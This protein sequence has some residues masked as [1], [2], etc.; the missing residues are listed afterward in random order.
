MLGG[1][2]SK[3]RLYFYTGH[4]DMRK[5][6][7]GLSGLVSNQ[8]DG[9]PLSGD[10]FIFINRRRTLLKLLVWDKGGFVIYYKRLEAGTFEFPVHNGSA[11]SLELSREELL[12]IIDGIELKSIRKRKRYE[13]V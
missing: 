1:W 9:D 6:F 8:L 13:K 10:V 11:K 7:N 3:V 12:L 2:L 4:A 5:G